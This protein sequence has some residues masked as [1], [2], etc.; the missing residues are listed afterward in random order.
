VIRRT[1]ASCKGAL[2]WLKLAEFG[3]RK[4]DKGCLRH[5]DNVNKVWGVEADYDAG[6]VGFNTAVLTI[7]KAGI[8][9]LVYTS[10]GHKEERPRWRALC[11]SSRP[12]APA[13]RRQLIGRLNGLFGGIFAPES[14]ALSQSY[15][16]GSVNQNPAHAVAVVEGAPIDL[17]NELDEIAQGPADTIAP[18]GAGNGDGK[19]FFVG[20]VDER[21]LIDAIVSGE[22]YHMPCIRLVGKWLIQGVSLTAA[23]NRLDTYF[24]SVFPPDRDE[25]WRQRRA[26]IARIVVGLYTK[27]EAKRADAATSLDIHIEPLDAGDDTDPIPPRRWLLQH[28][29]CRKFVSAL[30][31]A[32]GD[33]KTAIRYAQYLAVAT[34][35]NLTGEYVYHRA[36]VL[37]LCLEDHLDETRRRVTAAMI[38]HR[39]TREMIKGW[40]FCAAPRGL[41][42]MV[43]DHE[44]NPAIGPLYG[45]LRATIERLEIGLV[46]IDPFIKSHSI[47][48]N[49]NNGIDTVC[50]ALIELIEGLDCAAD[51]IHH[52]RKGDASPGDADRSRG[53]SALVDACRLVSTV[54]RMTKAEAEAFGMTPEARAGLIRVDDAK[55]NLAPRPEHAIWFRLVGV[56]LLNGSDLYPDG[57]NVQTVERWYPPDLFA[58]IDARTANAILDKIDAGLPDGR[59]YSSGNAATGRAAWPLV[60]EAVPELNEKQARKVINTWIDKRVL[61]IREYTD[62]HQKRP[63]SGLFVNAA[64][65][66][67]RR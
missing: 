58:Q 32:G 25:R 1:T 24:D 28:T 6:E 49:H 54:T 62:P 48:E 41:K 16:F 47:E 65:R 38:H 12:L 11:P 42:L 17:C 8:A 9:A 13:E 53:A 50:L 2:P 7:E 35:R 39:I 44:G 23:R 21:A 3:D 29:F 34:G 26:D 19:S 10:P 51:V 66:P 57:D 52:A 33:G 56:P 15:Y 14:F 55:I 31:G 64:R 59:R 36:R 40:L 4:T 45:E 18:R 46:G 5:D 63:E 61:E 20:P 22:S 37:I 67:G 60:C 27:E 43:L 30:V